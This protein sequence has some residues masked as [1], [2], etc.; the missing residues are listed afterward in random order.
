MRC[1]SSEGG[2]E[3][4]QAKTRHFELS[5]YHEQEVQLRRHRKVLAQVLVYHQGEVMVNKHLSP[6]VRCCKV[7]WNWNV[8][9]ED[10]IVEPIYKDRIV[11][12][13]ALLEL[14]QFVHT[15]WRRCIDTK[16]GLDNYEP[17]SRHSPCLPKQ[18]RGIA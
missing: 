18:C 1:L 17:S 16:N 15:D 7:I 11:K 4:F 2:G 5:I 3:Q 14:K 9:M 8:V 13:I 10:L 12:L 6:P